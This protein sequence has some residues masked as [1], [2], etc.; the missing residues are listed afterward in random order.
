[1]NGSV[2]MVIEGMKTQ[3]RQGMHQMYITHKDWPTEVSI[4]IKIT[5][6]LGISVIQAQT[7]QPMYSVEEVGTP[8]QTS[9]SLC[10]GNALSAHGMG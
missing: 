2:I 9:S 10:T 7:V 8:K 3:I 4:K 6:V 5:P 1:M